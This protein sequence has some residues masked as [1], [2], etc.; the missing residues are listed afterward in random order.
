M[1]YDP[2]IAGGLA[3]VVPT[4]EPQREVWLA[5]Q[6]SI[7]G[8]LSFNLSVSLRILGLLDLAAIRAA[9]QDLVDRHDALR[10]TV[11]P[12]GEMLCILESRP[13][14]VPLFDFSLLDE[15]A[16]QKAVDA[17]LRTSVETPFE[18]SQE[19]LFRA[20]LIQLAECEHIL[21]LTAHH[22]VC[23]GWSWWAI[24]RELGMLYSAH[25]NAHAA[26]LPD[27][28]SFAEHAMRERA[29]N[30]DVGHQESEAYWLSQFVDGGPVLDLPT[31][32]PRPM[33]RSF[34]SAREDYI[35]DAELLDSLRSRAADRGAGLFAM[36][37][38]GF[39]ALLSR[40]SGQD[41]LVIGIPAAGQPIAGH[42][43]L[44]GHCVSLLP[45]RACLDTAQSFE[46][47]LDGVQG[48]LLDALEHQRYTFGTLLKKLKVQRDPAR[49]P[50]VSVLFNLDQALD[51]E[52]TAFSGLTVEFESNPRSF[53]TFELFVNAVQANGKLRLECQYNR[54]LFDA[55][56]VRCW[57]RAYEALLSSV[58]AAN[59]TD[60]A[61][62]SLLDPTSLQSLIALQPP[63]V[64]FDR[65]CRMHE[66]FEAQCDRTPG[67]IALLSGNTA[68]S[69]GELESRANRIAHVLRGHGVYRGQ[70]VGLAVGRGVDMLCALLGILKSGAGY[71]PLDPHY[72]PERL[73]NMARDA[74][75]AAL[76]TERAHADKFHLGP[77]PV[78][79]VDG[80]DAH[81]DMASAQR[82]GRD[83]RAAQPESVAYVIYTSGSTGSPKG[84][85]VP[86]RAVSNFLTGMLAEPGIDA[87]DR[88]LAVTTLSFDIA[89]LELLLPLAVGA[90]ILLAD[91][92]TT[93]DGQ[94]LGAMLEDTGATMMQAT[95]STWRVLLDSGWQGSKKLKA[96]CGG[97]AL[98]PELSSA[99]LPRC[100]SLW[101][102][103]GPTE[104]TVWSTCARIFAPSSGATPDVHIGRP[105]ANTRIWILDK[106]GE[107]CPQGV[108][109]EI[110]IGGE[111]VTLGYIER[112]ELTAD[113]F[114]TEHVWDANQGGKAPCLYRT[115]DRGRW[116]PDG[117]LE[118]LG[119]L[120]QQVKVRGYRIE[121]GE[122]EANLTMREDVARSIV[123]VRED[124]PDDQRLVAY[125]V[126]AGTELEET[127]LREHLRTKLPAYMIPQHFIVIDALPLLPNGKID[128]NALPAPT[129]APAPARV[130]DSLVLAM[131]GETRSDPRIGY[132]AGVWSEL[133]GS[134]VGPDDNFFELG[135]HS[136]LAVQMANRVER[137]TGIRIKLIRLG[138]ETLSQVAASL[139]HKEPAPPSA[140]GAGLRFREGLRW[141]LGWPF[142]E[143]SR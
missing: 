99:L 37:L 61:R 140:R 55:S 76:V 88:L 44:V 72:P 85:C 96:L 87:E 83:D 78:L 63:P 105:I 129:S 119:R 142:T 138:S 53:E 92:E 35:I 118:H 134:P 125:I 5:D 73:A 40:L 43:F 100:A 29:R 39:Y 127:E 45:I 28:I 18:L 74:N 64:A 32:R 70:L 13:L 104:T 4:T 52:R 21:L 38:T 69:Y 1:D 75:L 66:F 16:R 136:M 14:P 3:C 71:V 15:L 46:I 81:L 86:H 133:L 113:R 31:D 110:C 90:E 48:Q 25:T 11:S 114:I 98:S 10:A 137:D 49:I 42:D 62:L 128:R 94:A 58:V 22:I 135:G 141:L 112:P 111:G 120:D 106:N 19:C 54:D 12:D 41:D 68:I 84:V 27:T 103:Y 116:R 77:K 95:P 60:L 9:L 97:E 33:Q 2:F 51:Q 108:P 130:G 79:L 101:N 82:I 34:V 23:D 124:R 6:V 102:M 57:L 143:H 26:P 56:T 107:L 50:L 20:E 80:Q 139:P 89:V 59:D 117:N 7:D 131:N 122:V 17:R 115:G 36:L 30:N 126:P 8:S 24:A 67:R 123:M 93:I 121:P 91:R 65:E 109:G 132:L 47:A